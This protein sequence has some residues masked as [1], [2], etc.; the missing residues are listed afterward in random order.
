MRRLRSFLK[1]IALSKI[2]LL[3]AAI[4]TSAFLGDMILIFGEL[5]VFESNPYI[6]IISYMVFPGIMTLGLLMIPLGI[7]WNLKR[8][9]KGYSAQ[10]VTQLIESRRLDRMHVIQIIFILSLVNLVIFAIVG[11]RG[12][13]F[14]ESREF[15]GS[16][17][18]EVMHPE[19]AA[20]TRS[21]HSEISC[22][23]CH[24]G[25]GAGWFVKSKLSGMR[26]V[27]AVLSK[28]YSRPIET[29]IHNLRPAREVCEVCHRPEIF[30]GNRIRVIQHFDS[31]EENTKTY[32][33]LNMR[34][35]GGGEHGRRAHGIHW[36]VSKEHQVVYHA[37]D[38][39]RENIVWVKLKS[40]GGASRVW[41]QPGFETPD[42]EVEPKSRLM[43]CVD[44]HNRP[45]HIFLPPDVALDEWM[46]AGEIDSKIPWIRKLA[47]EVL[48][49]PYATT[50][51]AIAGISKFP[52]IYKERHPGI[53]EKFRSKIEATVP[54]LQEIH[55]LFVYPEMNISWNTYNSLIG[56]STKYTAACFR[57][58]NGIL[59]D[60]DKKPISL[61]CES[62]HYILAGQEKNP[63]ILKMLE[64]Q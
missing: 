17:C 48:T 45:T 43:D 33:V 27:I 18:H 13:H 21:P 55:R 35:G 56:H 40:T 54:K 1:L 34:V 51:D 2:S 46:A 53:W 29:P 23:E 12:F 59:R 5:F 31:D 14:T 62:C 57:C 3:G 36:H 49:V 8:H 58:H 42:E 19:L 41:R 15:C 16:L 25:P 32:T 64:A 61:E 7:F 30:H 4:V 44:C 38:P 20:Y 47:E 39:R 37:T 52:E 24:I 26:Q 28:S 50:E 9:G 22:V 10:A 60:L 63:L 6:G 11:Y